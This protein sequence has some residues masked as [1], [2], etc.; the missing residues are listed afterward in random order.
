MR[1]WSQKRTQKHTNEDNIEND[2]QAQAR[3]CEAQS[4]S[5]AEDAV[6][7]RDQNILGPPF[8]ICHHAKPNDV[9]N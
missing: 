3:H 5:K 8:T 9:T 7:H 2:S 1:E 4:G 6:R